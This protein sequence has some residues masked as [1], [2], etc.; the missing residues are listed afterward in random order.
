MS[1]GF[2]NDPNTVATTCGLFENWKMN[3]DYF[4]GYSEYRVGSPITTH[5]H[6]WDTSY[7]YWHGPIL[8][9]GGSYEL[10]CENGQFVCMHSPTSINVDFVGSRLSWLS[11]LTT[12]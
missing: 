3:G 5:Y 11:T 8:R 10:K 7:S 4:P 6:W 12:R 2:F 9:T 1:G